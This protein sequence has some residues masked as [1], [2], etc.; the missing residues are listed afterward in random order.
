MKKVILNRK[1]LKI[2]VSVEKVDP[3]NGTVIV[4]HGLGGFKEQV[5]VQTFAKAFRKSNYTVVTF[6]TTNSIGESDGKFEDAT[7]TSYYQDLEDVI[8]WVKKEPWYKRP[9]VLSGHSLGGFSTA[10]YAENYPKSVDALAPISPVVS[11]KLSLEAHKLYEPKETKKW[12]KTGW[13]I[14]KSNSK[15]GVIKKLPWSHIEDRLKYSL[16]ENID[17]L[18]MP[19]LLIVGEK[20]TSTPANHVQFLYKEIPGKEKEIHI[21]KDAPH[22]F[23]DRKH[24]DEI[25]KIFLSWIK[26]IK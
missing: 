21:I 16:L 7:I 12:E 8:A 15:P 24:L 26:K 17:K 11:G 22:T 6:D 14:K 13:Q 20:D 19:I 23:V 3:S 4:M 1:N 2:V 10:F 18:T 5:H 25:N 9:F